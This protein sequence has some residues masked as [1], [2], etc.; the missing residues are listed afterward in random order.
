MVPKKHFSDWRTIYHLSYPEGDSIN[1]YIPKEPYALQYVRVD[2]AIRILLSLGPGSYM[3]KTDPKSAFRLIPIHPGDWHLMGIYWQS[4]Y[5]VDLFL[6]FGLRSAPF[7]FN[8]F[9]DTLEWI[10]QN[11]YGLQHVLH[12]LDD[13][14]IAEPTLLKCL[15]NFRTLLRVF[16]SLQAP[17]VDSKTLALPKN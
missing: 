9:S 1:D 12:I 4:Q 17:L 2:G 14:F 13:F 8:Q 5:Y 7:L 3:A 15:T 11:N 6:P 10:L 16:M